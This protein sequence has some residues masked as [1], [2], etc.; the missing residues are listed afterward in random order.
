[1]QCLFTSARKRLNFYCKTLVT[2]LILYRSLLGKG[3]V[4]AVVAS[5]FPYAILTSVVTLSVSAAY[6]C[7]MLAL[8]EF[9][10]STSLQNF[11]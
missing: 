10:G 9:I 4:T 8:A 11:V 7:T 2:T 1:M 5:S 3:W 6:V